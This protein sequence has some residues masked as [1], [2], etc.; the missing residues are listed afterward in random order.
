[1]FAESADMAASLCILGL[2]PQT[3]SQEGFA[4]WTPITGGG[5]VVVGM[6]V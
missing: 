3:P 1:M 6:A 2:A 5:E 4:P